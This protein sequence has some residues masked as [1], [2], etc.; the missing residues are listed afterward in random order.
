MASRLDIDERQDCTVCLREVSAGCEHAET[1]AC[2]HRFHRKC[3]R[4]WFQRDATC[5]T[6]RHRCDVLN[7]FPIVLH[8]FVWTCIRDGAFDM[9]NARQQELILKLCYCCSDMR[10]FDFV[11]ELV[12]ER[13][14]EV[15]S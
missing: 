12:T 13:D 5:P 7:H 14:Y 8:A 3:V 2:G 4:R 15:T 1:L 6:C 10:Q 9:L 11:V